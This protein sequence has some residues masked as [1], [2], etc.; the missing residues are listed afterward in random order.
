MPDIFKAGVMNADAAAIEDIYH[1]VLTRAHKEWGMP[2]FKI[3][4]FA[5]DRVPL[6]SIMRIMEIMVQTGKLELL[7]VDKNTKVNYYR[8]VL[9]DVD[10]DGELR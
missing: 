5:K 9:P 2:E 1:F 10:T 4:N 8:A 6:H 7:G 3:V